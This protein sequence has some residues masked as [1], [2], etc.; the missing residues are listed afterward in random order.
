MP[1]RP[2]LQ[3]GG[4]ASGTPPKTIDLNL[5]ST[6]FSKP[7]ANIYTYTYKYAHYNNKT[8]IKPGKSKSNISK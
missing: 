1:P 8:E 2:Q 6:P 3:T 7:D 4:L 5:V